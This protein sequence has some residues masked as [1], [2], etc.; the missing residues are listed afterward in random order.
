MLASQ[1]GS[2]CH[3]CYDLENGKKKFD[4]I[5][6]RIFYLRELKNI[7]FDVYKIGNHDL[8]TVDV[9]WSLCNFSCV[10]CGPD[11]SSKWAG[12]LGI[13]KATPTVEQTERFKTY[14]FEHA[15]RL[16]HVYMA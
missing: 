8:Q 1:P 13:K 4:I 14:I 11:F 3:T 7:P 6:D 12:E 9:R 2:N 16:K 5:S 15:H 10:Y